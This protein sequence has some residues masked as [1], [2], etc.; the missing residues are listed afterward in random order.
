MR[1]CL[2]VYV[3]QKYEVQDE[4][5]ISVYSEEEIRDLLRSEPVKGLSLNERGKVCFNRS[6]Y[7]PFLS[8]R[9]KFRWELSQLYR[10]DGVHVELC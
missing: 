3:D 7:L 9:D 5:G 8:V 1:T 2:K 10:E 6:M 4:S